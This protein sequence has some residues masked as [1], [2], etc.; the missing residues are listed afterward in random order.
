MK[1]KGKVEIWRSTKIPKVELQIVDKKDNVLSIYEIKLSDLNLGRDYYILFS[2]L[3]V[4]FQIKKNGNKIE[5]LTTQ[6]FLVTYST[7]SGYIKI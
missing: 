5:H 7:D 4:K 6:D 1:V 2:N 3:N